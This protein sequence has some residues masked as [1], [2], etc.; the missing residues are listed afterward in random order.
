MEILGFRIYDWRWPWKHPQSPV[1]G[2]GECEAGARAAKTI[3]WFL[4]GVKSR[5]SANHNKP[6]IRRAS[7]KQR[8]RERE[9]EPMCLFL[10]L[11]VGGCAHSQQRLSHGTETSEGPQRCLVTFCSV[12][13]TNCQTIK[14]ATGGT[15]HCYHN[16]PQHMLTPAA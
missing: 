7:W 9:R 3:I 16:S 2:S 6:L 10:V 15:A 4:L 13:R 8:K 1:R 14:A 11:C 12:T 5:P